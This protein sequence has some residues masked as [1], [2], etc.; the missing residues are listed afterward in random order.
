MCTF[1]CLHSI[2]G[3]YQVSKVFKHMDFS[4]FSHVLSLSTCINNLPMPKIDDKVPVPL[5]LCELWT[6]TRSYT[7]C[8]AYN[9]KMWSEWWL[10]NLKLNSCWDTSLGCTDACLQISKPQSTPKSVTHG[11][12]LYMLNTA[13][14]NC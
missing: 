4:N 5:F 8:D 11:L 1:F 3:L 7:S 14:Q 13:T 12:I 2:P 9:N 10:W 6:N